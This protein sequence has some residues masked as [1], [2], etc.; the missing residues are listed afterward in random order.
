LKRCR[1]VVAVTGDGT[2]DA[3]AL[4]AADV[5]LS[6][7]DGTAVAKEASDMTILDNSFSTIANAVMWGRSLYKNIQR[8][9]MFQ[10]TI[11]VVAC[12]VVLIGAFVGRESPLTVTQML[13]VNLIM[14]TFAAIAL[15]SLPPSPEVM[16]EKP[17]RLTESIISREMAWSIFGVG[18]LFTVLLTA[19]LLFLEHAD[20]RSVSDL[21]TEHYGAYDGLSPYELTLFFTTFVML[22][23]WNMF[24]AKAF[25]T[26]RSAFSHLS[27]CR[28]FMFIAV[29][30]LV[31]Q[32]FIVE[33]GGAMFNVTHL[34]CADWTAVILTTSTVLWIG[35]GVRRIG[36]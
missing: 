8:F 20:I 34:N 5:G 11:N 6:M 24:N 22:Q 26:G 9:I 36:N 21:L 27:E 32:V 31:G 2:N 3:P 19:L 25:M 14:D 23:F 7:G 30:I 35:E 33:L 10:M 13:W 4:N 29:I 17:R 28:G 15:A 12:L 1:L 16:R 18:G